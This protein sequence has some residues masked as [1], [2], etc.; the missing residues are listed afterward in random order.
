MRPKGGAWSIGAGVAR[1][2]VLTVLCTVAVENP[3][4]TLCA[5]RATA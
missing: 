1:L 5:C 4:Q 3:V 2:P